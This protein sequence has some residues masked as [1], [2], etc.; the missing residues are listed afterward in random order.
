MDSNLIKRYVYAVS[1]QLPRKMQA[2]VE[3]ELESMI[4]EMLEAKCGDSEPTKEDIK[5]VLLELGLPEELASKYVGDEDKS[6]LSGIYFFWFKKIVK[7]VL[8]I[9]MIG[10]AAGIIIAGVI[11]N[12]GAQG[13]V[14]VTFELVAKAFAGALNAAVYATVCIGITFF[15]MERKKANVNEDD[16]FAILPEVPDKQLLIKPSEP[17]F[18]IFWAVAAAVIML[19]FPHIIGVFQQGFGWTPLFSVEYIH[20]FWYLIVAWMVIAIIG[21]LIKL[22]ERCYNKKVAAVV[23]I[24]DIGIIAIVIAFFI[25]DKL[26]N[27][28][29]ANEVA[30]I[31]D[32]KLNSAV[33]NI[34]EH[35]NIVLLALIVFSLVLEIGITAY[36]AYRYDVR[37]NNIIQ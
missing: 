19:I 25:N 1:S 5:N 2:E 29:F 4:D 6:L 12:A 17:I 23:I 10:T 3:K 35:A 8:P 16:F 21:E 20:A 36:R 34:I 24:G 32:N 28:N 14:L 33:I 18:N 11:Q 31:F 30:R 13:T 26:I 27:P 9:A 22:A 15:I 7:L 37:R